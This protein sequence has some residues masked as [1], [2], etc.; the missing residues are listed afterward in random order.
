[1]VNEETIIENVMDELHESLSSI[2]AESSING[3]IEIDK[4]NKTITVEFEYNEVK[5]DNYIGL[6]CY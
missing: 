4:E 2:N 6:C 3:V 5:E 1:M